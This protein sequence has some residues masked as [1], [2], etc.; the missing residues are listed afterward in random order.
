MM[1]TNPNRLVAIFGKQLARVSLPVAVSAVASAGTL[2]HR[3]DFETAGQANDTI[4]S[5][6]GTAGTGTI[7]GGK[8]TTNGTTTGVTLPLSAVAGITGGFAIETWFYAPAPASFYNTLYSFDNG[9]SNNF[10]IACPVRSAGEGYDSGIAVKQAGVGDFLLR[11]NPQDSFGGPGDL[12]QMVVVYDGITLRYY[13]NGRVAPYAN[14]LAATGVN[15][16]TLATQIGI[17]SGA[18]FPDPSLVGSTHDFRIYDGALS[19][20]EVASV[21]A[22]GADASNGTL[23]AALSKP[24]GTASFVNPIMYGPDPA[25]TYANGFYYSLRT[26]GGDIR[27]RRSTTLR[28]MSSCAEVT[29][30][31]ANATIQGDIWAPELHFLDG[32]WYVTS[33]GTIMAGQPDYRMFVLEANTADPMGNYTY[34]GILNTARRAI[35]GSA[36]RHNGVNY[37]LWSQFDD[38]GQCLYLAPLAN[39][40]TLGTPHVRISTP[41]QGWE[42][43]GGNVNEGPWAIQRDGRLFVVYSG[44]GCWTDDYALGMLERTGADLLNPASWTKSGPHF[45]KQPGAY[46]PG[47]NSVIQDPGGQWWNIYHANNATGQGC[48]GARNIRAQR[49]YWNGDGTPYFGT[50]LPAG[51]IVTEDAD[52]LVARFPLDEIAGTTALNQAG[53]GNGSLQGGATWANP[54][55]A[56]NGSNAHVLGDAALGNDVQFSLT[57]AA[58]IRP[59]AFADYDGI[60]TKGTNTSPWALQLAAN[61]ALRFSAN[62]GA[63]SGAVGGGLWDSAAQLEAGRWQHVA[64]TY[65]GT[66]LRFYIDGVQD[67]YSPVVNLRFGISN[68]PIVL[69]ADFPGG[70]EFFQGRMFDAR[71]HGRTLTAEEITA[72]TTSR[73][74]S[75][76]FADW[77]AEHFGDDHANATI[78]GALVD[79]DQDGLVNLLEYALAGDPRSASQAAFPV[80]DTGSGRLAL[81]FTRNALATDLTLTVQAAETLAGPWTGLAR[82]TGGNPFEVLAAGTGILESTAGATRSVEVRD[83]FLI[84]DPEHRRRFMRLHVTSP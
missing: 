78:A 62:F 77:Q 9:T 12:R 28:G 23:V 49:L 30:F 79:F 17:N 32:K 4:G 73:P 56:F 3:Y 7:S 54:G 65:D 75:T 58:W 70:D 57:L 64:V 34:K 39:P 43:H 40:W 59:D 44:S 42:Q 20:S 29:V 80:L 51:S 37:L 66:R 27:I 53:G 2:V 69:G 60:I 11:G 19:A 6:H 61:G 31:A 8:L 16:S 47:H 63:P 1:S 25:V 71:I 76:T 15:L 82:S 10:I 48:G 36:F 21:F 72:L 50:P 22:L 81:Q 14:D 55:L 83:L 68:E 26:T 46:G 18:P 35:D 24:S 38:E 52:F 74:P 5:A 41:A 45:V 13:Q 33:S 84:T 67:V